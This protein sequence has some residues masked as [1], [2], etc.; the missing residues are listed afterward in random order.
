MHVHHILIV[1]DDQDIRE[2]LAEFLTAEGH[3][4]SPATNGVDALAQLHAG[5]RPCLILLDLLMPRMTGWQF[6]EHLASSATLAEIP[7]LVLSAERPQM[8]DHERFSRSPRLTKPVHLTE[9]MD[10]IDV[11]CSAVG[12]G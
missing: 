6:A 11:G 10:A 4:S 9:L 8:R 12:A 7:Y 5:L 3:C 2:V 1:D